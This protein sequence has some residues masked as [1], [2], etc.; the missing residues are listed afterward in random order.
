MLLINASVVR[1]SEDKVAVIWLPAWS[2]A[3]PK[4][5]TMEA[6][7]RIIDD[8]WENHLDDVELHRVLFQ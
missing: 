2:N 3:P 7:Q 6:F 1:L 4:V 5:I 8:R